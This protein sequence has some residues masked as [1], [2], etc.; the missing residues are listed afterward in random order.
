MTMKKKAT[1]MM[2]LNDHNP[3]GSSNDGTLK[4]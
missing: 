4:S 3:E 2:T 1:A